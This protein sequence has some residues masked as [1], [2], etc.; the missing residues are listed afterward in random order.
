MKSII[1]D[2]NSFYYLNNAFGNNKNYAVNSENNSIVSYKK[3]NQI[4]SKLLSGKYCLCLTPI[5][6]S[7]VFFHVDDSKAAFNYLSYFV[8]FVKNNNIDLDLVSHGPFFSNI[9]GLTIFKH[10][11]KNDFTEKDIENLKDA[12]INYEANLIFILYYLIFVFFLFSYV[13]LFYKDDQKLLNVFEKDLI[14]E[15]KTSFEEKTILSIKKILVDAY[16]NKIEDRAIQKNTNLILKECINLVV[17][18]VKTYGDKYKTLVA[19]F[20]NF[21]D[22]P[23]RKMRRYYLDNIR[24]VSFHDSKEKVERNVLD[25]I[26]EAILS[27]NYTKSQSIYLKRKIELFY[28]SGALLEKNDSEDFWILCEEDNGFILTFDDF[29]R[30][31]LRFSN[32]NNADFINAF[33]TKSL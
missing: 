24:D 3:I 31:V 13:G 17:D 10:I 16:A 20:E 19:L 29:I 28:N 25:T 6:L 14:Y 23:V 7:E 1:F 21:K 9:Y 15:I 26:N 30:K 2:A 22:D 27:R 18:K 33:S 4:K 8:N 32:P 5:T 12:K 11:E